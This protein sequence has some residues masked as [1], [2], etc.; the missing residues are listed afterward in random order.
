MKTVKTT[1]EYTIFQ[2]KDDRYAVRNNKRKAINGDAKVEILIKEG[3]MTKPEP[4]PAEP[5]A[6]EESAEGEASSES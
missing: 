4:K 6:A 5:E 2:R 1:A 3:L